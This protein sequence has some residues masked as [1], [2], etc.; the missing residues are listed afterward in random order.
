MLDTDGAVKPFG[1]LSLDFT[2]ALPGHDTDAYQA[3][4][5]EQLEFVSFRNALIERWWN[6]AYS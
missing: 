1:A 4:V 6:D 3:Y 2:N 5:A